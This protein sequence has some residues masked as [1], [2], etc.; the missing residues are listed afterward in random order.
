MV[1][2]REVTEWR[3]VGDKLGI[4][5]CAL[6]EIRVNCM[7]N[8]Q[9]CK[10]RTCACTLYLSIQY[11]Y[12]YTMYIFL[13]KSDCLGCVV[14]LCFVVC[15]TML[16]S[17]FLPSHLSLKHVHVHVHTCRGLSSATG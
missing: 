12:V 11:I 9:H 2:I 17:F 5:L 6:E 8:V 10:V 4:E 15:L 1:V 16:A 3:E 7:N 14:L 13:K